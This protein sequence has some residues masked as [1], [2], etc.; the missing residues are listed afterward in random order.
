MLTNG[1]SLSGQIE[2]ARCKKTTASRER[3]HPLFIHEILW[4]CCHLLGPET[5]AGQH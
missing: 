5:K 1:Y 3:N 2:K 4:V